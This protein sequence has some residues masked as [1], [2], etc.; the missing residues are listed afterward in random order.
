ME[1]GGLVL[2]GTAVCTWVPGGREGREGAQ[3]LRSQSWVLLGGKNTHPALYPPHQSITRFQWN[4]H[5]PYAA[6][7]AGRISLK[8]KSRV[9]DVA[10][11]F[12]LQNSKLFPILF[13]FVPKKR[14]QGASCF[15]PS[16]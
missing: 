13:F 16:C 10:S 4:P 7:S 14:H 12:M 5:K 8:D 9:R 3:V 6:Q 2:R 11:C 1:Q 15:S